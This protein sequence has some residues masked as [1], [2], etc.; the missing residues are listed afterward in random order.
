[1]CFCSIHSFTKEGQAIHRLVDL[2]IPVSD[3]IAEHDCR[4]ELGAEDDAS[5]DAIESSIEYVYFYFYM[6]F[7]D[8]AKPILFCPKGRITFTTRSRG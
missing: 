6:F 3:L 2:V 4:L 5:A 8:H 1:M 7:E